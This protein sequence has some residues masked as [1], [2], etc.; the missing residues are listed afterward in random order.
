MIPAT[1]KEN[2]RGTLLVNPGGPGG[3]G[4]EFV[5]RS[6]QELSRIVGPSFDVLGFDPR[7]VGASLPSARCFETTLQWQLWGLQEDN[8]VLN[9][10][11][12][13]V[14]VYRARERLV[15]ERCEQKIGGNGGIGRFA[16][17]ASV[18]RDMLEIVQQLGQEKLQFWG[19]VSVQRLR[20][21]K[22]HD[23]QGF[24]RAMALYSGNISPRC[25]PTKSGA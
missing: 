12:S 17:S 6:G 9:V 2:Y 22:T 25:T 7:G 5:G 18:A 19:F 1:D 20:T 4:T 14:E 16:G 10:T 13:S 23:S 15:A 11:D 8:R 3:S 21:I 24:T